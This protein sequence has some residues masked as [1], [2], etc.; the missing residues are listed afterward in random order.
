M[1][2][3]RKRSRREFGDVIENGKY[4]SIRKS[5]KCHEKD[6]PHNSLQR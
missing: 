6:T 5:A 4:L 1:S 3:K 2:S